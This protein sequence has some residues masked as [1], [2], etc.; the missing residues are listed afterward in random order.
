MYHVFVW[1]R[2]FLIELLNDL[3]MALD[4]ATLAK[5]TSA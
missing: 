2:R 5:S 1:L 3:H 4:P